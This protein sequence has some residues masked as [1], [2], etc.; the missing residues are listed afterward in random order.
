MQCLQ[1]TLERQPC[2]AALKAPTCRLLVESLRYLPGLG[3]NHSLPSCSS[4]QS[5]S[6]SRG[7]APPT[8]DIAVVAHWMQ[9]LT[10]AQVRT[11]RFLLNSKA[12]F[13][14]EPLKSPMFADLSVREGRQGVPGG[15]AGDDGASGQ[16]LRRGQRA[17]RPDHVPAVHEDHR[18]LR[19]GRGGSQQGTVDLLNEDFGTEIN[20][21]GRFESLK[22]QNVLG[23]LHRALH[24]QSA[25]VWR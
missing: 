18:L 24:V 9:A 3:A 15:S 19:P 4:D 8:A 12:K 25:P 7:L 20:F 5:A 21:C 11:F 10:E 13:W 23:V 17:A 2:D 14:R 6:P 1:R 16:V 22:L